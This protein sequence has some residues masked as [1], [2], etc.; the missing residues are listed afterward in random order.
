MA[1]VMVMIMTMMMMVDGSGDQ[2]ADTDNII[3]NR[4]YGSN[5][6]YGKHH[7]QSVNDV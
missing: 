2:G 6:I 7:S 3:Q 1:V 5:R 4:I